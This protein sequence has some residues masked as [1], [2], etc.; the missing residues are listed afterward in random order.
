MRR[1]SVLLVSYHY[2]PAATPASQRV[3]GLARRLHERGWEVVVLT[4]TG[5]DAAG[6]EASPVDVVRTTRRVLR[7]GSRGAPA[8]DRPLLAGIP[9]LK[10]IMGF[11]DRY[12]SWSFE[13][14]PR[15][16]RVLSSRRIDVVLS[17]S[18][19][20]SSHFAVALARSVRRFRWVA[21]FRDPWMFPS[22][23][24]PGGV[25]ALLQRRMERFV[26]RRCDRV[27]VNTPG[28]QD[29]LLS[30]NPGLSPGRVRIAT[31]GYDESLFGPELESS[32]P[33]ETADFTYVGEVYPGML[34]RY[35]AALVV[36]RDRQPD[37]V[38]RLAV[39]GTIDGVE[40]RRLSALG[41]DRFVEYRGFVAHA[42]SIRAMTSA[43][44]LLALLPAEERWRTCVP[45]KVYWYLAARRP[46]VAFVPD[47]DTAALV[48]A[49]GAGWVLDDAE[50]G[51]L[52]E[53]LAKIVARERA[54]LSPR[55]Q[56]TGIQRYA[57][58]V[59][60]DGVESVLKEVVGGNPA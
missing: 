31:N 7:A 36:L 12:A 2:L 11:P 55:L 20:H 10:T 54:Q 53:Q 56:G 13:L 27:L 26:I 47:G 52:A 14:V 58:S 43:R 59:I 33:T 17:S 38:P 21:E 6:H 1:P 37:L 24:H 60:V 15:L 40:Q 45:S 9:V 4:G 41:L 49:T 19:P 50:A 51:V 23:R 57:M 48:R 35:C 46:I 29:T 18:P 44:A 28:N 5:P 3:D 16:L 25:S 34:E 8:I 42:Q 39:Y 30:A 32:A 22:R